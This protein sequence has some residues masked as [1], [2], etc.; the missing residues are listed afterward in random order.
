VSRSNYLSK[1]EVI[2]K[3]EW[4]DDKYYIKNCL[5]GNVLYER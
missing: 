1:D 3:A 4:F 5:A 2:L